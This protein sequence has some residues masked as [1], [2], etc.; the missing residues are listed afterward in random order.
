VVKFTTL[1]HGIGRNPR[2]RQIAKTTAHLS[3]HGA[4]GAAV[5]FGSPFSGARLAM[6]TRLDC[7]DSV[8]APQTFGPVPC[9]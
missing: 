7:D 5:D 4:G 1:S 8:D 2:S 3:Y 6:I 9:S